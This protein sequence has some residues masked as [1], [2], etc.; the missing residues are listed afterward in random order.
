[1]SFYLCCFCFY[2]VSLVFFNTLVFFAL[3]PS[4][5]PLLLFPLILFEYLLSGENIPFLAKKDIDSFHFII[6]LDPM[7]SGHN[8]G[9]CIF[10]MNE[11]K[12][13]KL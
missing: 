7:E 13:K 10:R 9:W 3:F 11:K 5:F 2:H 12:E 4:I 1:M 8:I 6:I